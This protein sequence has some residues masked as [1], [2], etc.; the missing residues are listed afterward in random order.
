MKALDTLVLS[1]TYNFYIGID[2]SK[3][4][5]NVVSN[6]I[7]NNPNITCLILDYNDKIDNTLIKEIS[8]L[9]LTK[10][11]IENYGHPLED[12]DYKPIFRIETLQYLTLRRYV[13]IKKRYDSRRMR[14]KR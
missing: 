5:I 13:V 9:K 10:L 14:S 12:L 6:F 7:I 2:F 11:F 3:V 8:N 4:V 1:S